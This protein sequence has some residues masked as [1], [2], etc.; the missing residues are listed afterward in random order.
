MAGIHFLHT[1]HAID[2]LK[3]AG[4][5]FSARGGKIGG[6]NLFKKTIRCVLAFM[7]GSEVSPSVNKSSAASA[8]KSAIDNVAN[9]GAGVRNFGEFLEA[10]KHRWGEA[11]RG[12][13]SK[14]RISILTGISSLSPVFFLY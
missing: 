14:E 6:H 4:G 11:V 3:N 12:R 2:R 1:K 8:R 9:N 5:L 7:N 10:M 13:N